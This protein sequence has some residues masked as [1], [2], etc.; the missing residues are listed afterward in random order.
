MDLLYCII[1]LI[2]PIAILGIGIFWKVSPP[3]FQSEG[4][5]YRTNLSSASKEAWNFAHYHCAK[6][7]VRIGFMLLIVSLLLLFVFPDN[8]KDYFLWLI[9]GQMVLFCVSA[10]LVDALL[11]SSFDEQGKPLK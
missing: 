1:A 5:A 6:L 11:K 7:W 8:R 9:G 10:F 2:P 4:L 3:K